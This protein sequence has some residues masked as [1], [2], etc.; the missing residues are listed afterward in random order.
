VLSRPQKP[1][2]E[3]KSFPFYLFSKQKTKE[4]FAIQISASHEKEDK[5]KFSCVV[6]CL[7]IQF[8]FRW[9]VRCIRTGGGLVFTLNLLSHSLFTVLSFPASHLR[10]RSQTTQHSPHLKSSSLFHPQNKGEEEKKAS[11]VFFRIQ[12][13]KKLCGRMCLAHL[14]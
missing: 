3:G 1:I 13:N 2:F 8:L 11:K 4:I 7:C 14:I 10:Q 5:Q 6:C 12:R 9:L